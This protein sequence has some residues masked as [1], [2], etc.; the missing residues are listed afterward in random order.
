MHPSTSTPS[1]FTVTCPGCKQRLRFTPADGLPRMKI[2]C[3]SCNTL[4]GVRRP[5]TP[6]RAADGSPAGAGGPPPPTYPGVPV[7]GA[8]ASAADGPTGAVTS[9]P[10]AASGAATAAPRKTGEPSFP[11]GLLVAGRYRV[12]SFIAQGG[13]GEVYEVEDLELRD[14]VALKTVR[15]EIAE[16][17]LAIE[18]FRREIQ[19]SRKVT[20]PNVCRIFD[21]AHHHPPGAATPPIIF[22]TMELLRGETLAQ[23]LRRGPLGGELLPIARQ[24]AQG[25]DAAHQAGIVHRDLKPGNV[26]LVPRGGAP[27]RAVVTDF[28]LARLTAGAQPAGLTLTGGDGL[29]GTP[30]YLAPEQLEGGEITPAVDIYAFGIVLYEMVSGTV[31]FLSDSIL[32]TAVKRLKEAPAS[33]RVYVPDLDPRWEQAILRCLE[34]DPAA[35]FASCLDA[36]AVAAGEPPHT[37]AMPAAASP[38]A[39]APAPTPPAAISRPAAAQ[40]AAAMPA[41]AMPATATPAAATARRRRVQVASL[42][43]LILLSLVLA[44]VRYRDWRARQTAN[45]GGFAAIGAEGNADAMAAA[46]LPPSFAN[47][48]R[49]AVAVLGFKDLS[50]SAASAW[51]S[52]ALAEMLGAELAAGGKLRIVA[53]ETVAR[54][55]LEL[56][57]DNSESLARDTLARLRTLLGADQVV[58]GSYISLDAAAAP[59]TTSAA[60]AAPGAA[61]RKLRLDVRIQ[62]AV[63][64]ET[65]AMASET[66]TEAD[67]F[68]LV[69]RVGS[70]LRHELGAADTTPAAGGGPNGAWA[71][72]PASPEAARLYAEG[73]ERLR[74]FEPVAARD[75]LVKAVAADPRNAMA[76]SALAA[77]WSALGYDGKQREEVKTAFDLAAN[78]APEE[79]LSIEGRYRAAAGDWGRAIDIYRHLWSLYPD[80]LEHGLLLAAAETAAGR[81]QEALITAKALHALPPPSRDDAR[82][83][84]AEATAAGSAGDFRRQRAAAE[85]AARQAAAAGASLLVA[86]SRLL[87]C[88]ALRNLGEAEPALSA[89]GEGQRLYAAAGDRAGVAEALTH[90]ANVRYDRGDRAGA[91]LLYEQALV[92]YRDIGNRGAEAGE[93]NNIAVVLKSQG[94]LARAGELYGEVLAISREIGSRSGEAYALNNLA[95]VMLRRGDLAGAGALLEQCLQIRRELEDRSGEAY[96]LDNLGVALRRRGDLA[97][98]LARHQAALAIRRQIGQKIGEVASLNNLGSTLVEQG[99]LAAAS[100]DFDQA[101]A[102]ARSIGSQSSSAYSLFGQAEILAR[103]GQLAAAQ[104]KHQAAL[105]LRL[106]LGER[107]TAAESRMALAR[108]RLEAGDA[109]QA[110]VLARQAAEELKLQGSPADQALALSLAAAA[111]GALQDPQSARATIERAGA[112]A[113]GGQDLRARLT[114]ALRSALL[115]RNGDPARAGQALAAVLA[116]AERG[117]LLDLRLEAG[118]A[119]AQTEAARGQMD[120]ARARL[121]AIVRVARRRGF[122]LLARRAHAA[123][124]AS[125]AA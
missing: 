8:A 13:M 106:G 48:P 43:A 44:Y 112:L 70:R 32:A 101:L 39:A 26:L 50:G 122:A 24:I 25:L 113:G 65:T 80:N 56:K 68:A 108:V 59:T 95:G 100:R 75:L 109:A 58:L 11:A 107:G 83:D 69:T 124:L 54:A 123:A 97:G 14:R 55:K 45:D 51:L 29:V 17:A 76:H 41:A 99:D 117:G 18:R 74:R 22:L 98:A 110:G 66:G 73:L 4:F 49:R 93:L 96:A 114:V 82:I 84:L 86:E 125:P 79:R 2:H 52:P 16:G 71:A 81:T 42:A 23:R 111:D 12:V 30:A 1:S 85:R 103:Q 20:H 89:C 90:S 21:V 37:V 102:M 53:G 10:P 27:P 115:E 57:L 47:P 40:P 119:L 87:A 19:L 105:D 35:R 6:P 64:G 7:A 67:L 72:M 62:D 116:G 9:R 91:Q 60:P 121:A 28:G 3:T 77:A 38:P 92:T 61:G 78:L 94:N 33:P 34:R 5:G 88:R 46:G 120:G 63:A 36:V 31:P 15:P 104:A 118:I